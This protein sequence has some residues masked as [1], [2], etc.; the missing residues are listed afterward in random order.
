MWDIPID[1]HRYL[2]EPVSDQ[3]HMRF[4]MY[5]RLINFKNQV[6]KSSKSVLK[7]VYSICQNNCA[8]VT[9]RNLRKIML[10]CDL[11]TISSLNVFDI[12][13]LDYFPIPILDEW[14]IGFIKE[15]L[16]TRSGTFEIPGFTTEE[17]SD[18]LNFACVS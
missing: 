12:D 17:I 11:S 15:L 13:S 4:T 16:C 8:S 10:S 3:P 7:H 6:M 14:R 2:I 1:T 18:L 9:G 5:K